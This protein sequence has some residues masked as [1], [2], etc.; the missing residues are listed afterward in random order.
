MAKTITLALG[1]RGATA[2]AELQRTGIDPVAFLEDAL[3]HEADRVRG[4]AARAAEI[5]RHEQQHI[6]LEDIREVPR[7]IDYIRPPR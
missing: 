3:I 5:Y 7:Q 1:D 2:Y 6:D 4:R